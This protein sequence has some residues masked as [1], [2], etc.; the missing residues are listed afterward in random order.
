MTK[1]TVDT[2]THNQIRDLYLD[3]RSRDEWVEGGLGA[4]DA[5]YRQPGDPQREQALARCVAILNARKATQ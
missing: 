1:L 3:L 5:L 4:E 2:V